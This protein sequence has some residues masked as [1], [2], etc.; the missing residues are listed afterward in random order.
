MARIAPTGQATEF[1]GLY[2]LSGK[3]TSF[4][5]PFAVGVATMLAQSQRVGMAMLVVFF[6]AG[7]LLLAGVRPTRA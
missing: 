4:A 3:L 2:A 1:F 5:G 7:A 6:V